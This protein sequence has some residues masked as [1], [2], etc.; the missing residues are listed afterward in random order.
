M[1]KHDGIWGTVCDD[2]FGRAEA[3]T[4]CRALGFNDFAIQYTNHHPGF[5]EPEIP[6]WMDAV[7]C[8]SDS[9]NFLE[10]AHEGWGEEDCGHSEDVL[11]TCEFL[12][13]QFQKNV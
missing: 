6:I 3:N 11:L 2:E 1:V 7:D 12:I 9:T 8:D 10:C 5:S 13:Y 4:A